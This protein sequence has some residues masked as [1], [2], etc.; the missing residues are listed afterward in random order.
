MASVEQPAY[1]DIYDAMSTVF[2]YPNGVKLYAYCRQQNGCWVQVDDFFVGTKGYANI[3]GATV[4][5]CDLKGNVVYE[6]KKVPSNMYQLEHDA[7]FKAIRSG[8]ETY[9]NHWTFA[10]HHLVP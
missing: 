4:Q 8:G 7:L 2:E 6:Q 5:I 10:K 9:I 1:G 3:I